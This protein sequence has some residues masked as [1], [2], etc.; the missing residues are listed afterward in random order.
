MQFSL[1]DFGSFA[2]IRMSHK[3]LK[4]TTI[5]LVFFRPESTSDQVKVVFGFEDIELNETEDQSNFT[6]LI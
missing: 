3:P 2:P 1:E 4:P 5:S 6:N